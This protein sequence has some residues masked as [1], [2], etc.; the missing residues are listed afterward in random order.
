[1]RTSALFF[2]VDMNSERRRLRPRQKVLFSLGKNRN[3]N[4]DS[5]PEKERSFTF[6]HTKYSRRFVRSNTQKKWS[7]KWLMTFVSSSQ[8]SRACRLESSFTRSL[9]LF[10]ELVVVGG[11]RFK[12]ILTPENVLLLFRE[13]FLSRFFYRRELSLLLLCV[14]RVPE[15]EPLFHTSLRPF[16]KRKKN[17]TIFFSQRFSIFT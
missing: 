10:L 1:M 8:L 16:M 14:L 3:S 2:P 4:G 11:S 12:R 6:T 7:G 13:C 9:S 15:L 17:A 5:R